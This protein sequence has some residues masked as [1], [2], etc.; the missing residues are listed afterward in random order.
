MVAY[1]DTQ[2]HYS[3]AKEYKD[4]AMKFD[5]SARNKELICFAQDTLTSTFAKS[6]HNTSRYMCRLGSSRRSR[7]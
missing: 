2:Q 5:R 6:D 1:Q 4:I 3:R 7:R